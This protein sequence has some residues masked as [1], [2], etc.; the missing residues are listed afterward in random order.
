[1]SVTTRTDDRLRLLGAALAASD[2][3]AFEQSQKAYKA[4]R[5]ADAAHRALSA[6]AAHPAVQA[7]RQQAG[8]GEGLAALARQAWLEAW[9]GEL[10]AQLADFAAGARLADFYA[11]HAADFAQAEADAREVLAR[12]DLTRFLTDLLGPLNAPLVFVPNLL[13]PGRTPMAVSGP[14]E[15]VVTAPPPLAWGTSHPWRYNERPDEALAIMAEAFGQHL[16]AAAL[17]AA[18][19]PQAE[20]LGLAA[21]VLFLREAEG[22]EAGDQLMVMQK[23][24]RGLKHLPAVTANLEARL[25]ERRAGQHPA[26]VADYAGLLAG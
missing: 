24:T 16:L 17:P 15:V 21:A 6:Q 26:G 12:A 23:R 20:V 18:L 4:H 10:A 9:P 2:W 7:I 11:D 19:Q 22:P 25:A 3:P 8:Q 5:V 1:M 13:F 14:A